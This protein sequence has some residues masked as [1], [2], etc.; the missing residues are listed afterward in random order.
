M[1][2]KDIEKRADRLTKAYSE[3]PIPVCEIV[4]KQGVE[5]YRANFENFRDTFSGFCDFKND[6]I[7]LNR[8]N[9]QERNFL[10]TAHE[11]GH[12]NLHKED[13]EKS[14]DDYA[15]LLK[16]REIADDEVSDTMEREADYF[17]V[18]LI[19]PRRLVEQFNDFY[20]IS[21]LARLFGVPQS[22]MEKRLK[23][24]L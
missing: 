19:M 6:R 7:Y 24:V 9:T 12:W 5:I 18:N 3:P 17:A 20:S 14:P 4:R 1:D 2:Y 10:A 23:S 13:F 15:F 21:E 22:L 16:D 11:F 8:E